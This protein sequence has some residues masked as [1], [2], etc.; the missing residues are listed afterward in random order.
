MKKWMV[1]GAVCAMV[2]FV[3]VQ[4]AKAASAPRD[5]SVELRKELADLKFQTLLK[6]AEAREKN[7]ACDLDIYQPDMVQE[8]SSILTLDSDTYLRQIL[9]NPLLRKTL[10]H[11]LAFRVVTEQVN[12]YKFSETTAASLVGVTLY[13]PGRGAYGSNSYDLLANGKLVYSYIDMTDD[14]EIVVKKKEGTWRVTSGPRHKIVLI[15]MVDGVEASYGLDA[16]EA[17]AF[18][19]VHMEPLDAGSDEYDRLY[20]FPSECDA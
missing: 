19:R 1:L 17:S 8:V 4:G 6:M 9:A 12:P 14:G 2:T 13:T 15:L 5:G 16:L 3:S 18:G 10:G 11:D 7:W 20:S